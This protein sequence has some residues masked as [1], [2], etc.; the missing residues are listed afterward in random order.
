MAQKIDKAH[1]ESLTAVPSLY[2]IHAPA[3]YPGCS[4]EESQTVVD[5]K[6]CYPTRV[7]NWQQS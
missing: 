1:V 7:R 3:N 2:G 4:P 6:Y 5:S